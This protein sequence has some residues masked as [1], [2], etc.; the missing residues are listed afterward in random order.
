[1]AVLGTNGAPTTLTTPNGFVV[2]YAYNMPYGLGGIS[3]GSTSIATAVTA[4]LNFASNS[5]CTSVTITVLYLGSPATYDKRNDRGVLLELQQNTGSWTTVAS[6]TKTHADLWG[7]LEYACGP[8][9]VDFVLNTPIAVTTAANTW[10]LQ[11]TQTGG[12]AGTLYWLSSATT[13]PGYITWSDTTATASTKFFRGATFDATNDKVNATG[14]TFVNGDKVTLVNENSLSVVPGGLAVSTW[15]F[16]VN[17]GANDFEVSATSGGAKIN[18][19]TAGSGTWHVV[20]PQDAII[21][22]DK[23][24]IDCDFAFKGYI[25]TGNT[26]AATCAMGC[27][28]SETALADIAMFEWENPAT[29]S[30]MIVLD[31]VMFMSAWSGFR[32][33]TDASPHDSTYPSQIISLVVPS[34]G[35]ASNSGIWSQKG[36]FEGM[37]MGFWL[38]GEDIGDFATTLTADAS[39]GATSISVT[40]ESKFLTGDQFTVGKEDTYGTGSIIL[41]TVTSTSAGTINFTPALATGNRKS[42]A[43]VIN[44]YP[45]AVPITIRAN[46]SNGAAWNIGV[47]AAMTWKNVTTEYIRM[48]ET[49][50]TYA[51]SWPNTAEDHLFHNV[52]RRGSS[53]SLLFL[54]APVSPVGKTV[55]FN[56][57][58][59]FYSGL[60]SAPIQKILG[61]TSATGVAGKLKTGRIIFTNCRSVH[62]YT[63]GLIGPASAINE[64]TIQN[65]SVENW[66]YYGTYVEGVN[67]IFENNTFWG[68]SNNSSY[69]A[70]LMDNVFSITSWENNSYDKVYQAIYLNASRVQF[71]DMYDDTFGP[72]VASATADIILGAN[73]FSKININSP[74]CTTAGEITFSGVSLGETVDGTQI[75]VIDENNV[76]NVDKVYR[77]YENII[78]TGDSLAD[79]TVHTSGTGKFAHKINAT[80]ALE[81]ATYKV[82][83]PTGD[84]SNRDMTVGVWFNI[85]SANYYAGTHTLPRLDI[86]YDNGTR[87]YS[88]ALATTGWQYVTKSFRPTTA[89]GE[90]TVRLLTQT[91]ASGADAD[92]VW[93]DWSV[94]YP[95]GYQLNLGGMDLAAKGLPVG[96]PISTS[97]SALDVWS[98]DPT[99]F[100]SNT[101]GDL[102]NRV[103]AN[104]SLI[105]GID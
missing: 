80:D 98:A 65:C 54:Q 33:G 59:T 7:G 102:V 96:P 86:D 42:G 60:V 92:V 37:G 18:I 89:Y 100:G 58:Y 53:N 94:L 24:T 99:T 5:N 1:M 3:G 4:A 70:V 26:T 91:D 12:T 101:V 67:L 39:I 64:L 47:P 61:V 76:A 16:V 81:I 8:T 63:S 79:T 36:G 45:T 15:Y 28:S 11:V 21:A 38:I 20:C 104:A 40:D 49:S 66:L 77:T 105:P 31:G 82:S 44:M 83:I 32:V 75:A 30:Y 93:D 17:A 29:A 13:T 90:L 72:T 43:S 57:C 62:S 68:Q 103:D 52:V 23:V 6:C 34:E 14:H 19:T 69:G 56:K 73:C 46:T 51:Y 74:T 9:T 35:A 10:R 27:R 48:A 95:Q 25:G 88:S 78:R 50:H 84:I 55:T 85:K 41:H 87:V 2:S 71:G 97:I 22:K